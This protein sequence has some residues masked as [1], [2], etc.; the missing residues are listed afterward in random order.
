MTFAS[1]LV[2]DVNRREHARSAVAMWTS[3]PYRYPLWLARPISRPGTPGDGRL[4]G[5]SC[6][7]LVARSSPASPGSSTT[8]PT[9]TRTSTCPRT[10]TGQSVMSAPSRD[11]DDPA[12]T[13][14]VTVT[15]DERDRADWKLT[16]ELVVLFRDGRWRVCDGGLGLD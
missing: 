8:R 10:S 14:T 3:R 6:T 1:P 9:G 15:S 4:P 5:N 12:A 16:G 2:V 7:P 11:G 13:M